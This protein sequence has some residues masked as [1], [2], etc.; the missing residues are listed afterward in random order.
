MAKTESVQTTVYVGMVDGQKK[1][2]HVRAK[3]Q[4]ELNKKVREIKQA[5]EEGKAMQGNT[6]FGYWADKWIPEVKE[7]KGIQ[8]KTL[9]MYK[10]ALNHINPVFGDVEFRNIKRSDFQ[11]F[12]NDFT[13]TPSAHTGRLPSKATIKN[14]RQVAAWVAKYA[15]SNGVQG[16]TA[17]Y[18]VEISKNAPKQARRA[19]T[20]EEIER[21]RETEHPAQIAAMIMT[22]AGLRRGELVP[23]LWSDIDL[24][25]GTI[26]VNKSVWYETNQPHLK[27]G[28]KTAAAVRVVPIPPVLVEYLRE[29][30]RSGK[31]DSVLVCPSKSN[32][33]HTLSTFQTM[34]NGYI[35]TLNYK[36]GFDVPH[37][38]SETKGKRNLPLM[39]EPFTA[40][41]CRHTFATL[42]FLQD[43][44]PVT[45][46]QYLGHSDIQTTINIYTDLKTFNRASLEQ[47]FKDKLKT[48][49]KVRTA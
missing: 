13:N 44:P 5:F 18:D 27:D 22:F 14:L 20:E 4:R 29:Y 3:N 40:H 8:P 31:V 28:G 16:V 11:T 23:L 26:Y 7:P 42:L 19:L 43:V 2:K 33:M 45:A 39:I 37:D 46:M 17:F 48:D 21:I 10:G 32:K 12:I 38:L 1:Y 30:K 47:S 9:Q 24:D 49:Y 36:Y 34:W 35:K 25:A 15:D 6:T 41:Y